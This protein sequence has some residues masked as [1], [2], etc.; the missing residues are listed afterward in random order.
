MSVMVH[1]ASGSEEQGK[2]TSQAANDI[3]TV[4]VNDKAEFLRQLLVE[5]GWKAALQAEMAFD[6]FKQMEAEVQK[7][8]LENPGQVFPPKELIFN[9]LNMTALEKV[10]IL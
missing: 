5:N 2:M 4:T 9:A 7:E 1:L 8:Y 10:I 6:Y 3:Q